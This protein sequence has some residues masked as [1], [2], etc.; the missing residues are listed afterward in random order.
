MEWRWGCAGKCAKVHFSRKPDRPDRYR[1]AACPRCPESRARIRSY[2]IP[3]RRYTPFPTTVP[4]SDIRACVNVDVVSGFLGCI[5]TRSPSPRPF[6][7]PDLVRSRIRRRGPRSEIEGNWKWRARGK[8]RFITSFFLSSACEEETAI[9][10]LPI[11]PQLDSR[12]QTVL[13]RRREEEWREERR[14]REEARLPSGL[15]SRSPRF[16]SIF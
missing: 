13:W 10:E 11:C 7:S 8:R 2:S 3:S 1:R 14:A 16:R 4:R 12:K 6:F 15:T 5:S 9:D